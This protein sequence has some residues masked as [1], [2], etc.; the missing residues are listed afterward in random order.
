M[1]RKNGRFLRSSHTFLEC[2]NQGLLDY[3]YRAV[4]ARDLPCMA[5]VESSMLYFCSVV[6]KEHKVVLTGECADEI[7]GGYPWFRSSKAFEGQNFPWSEDMKVRQ[8]L[9]SEEWIQTLPMEEYTR[10]AYEKTIKEVP[11]LE[12]EQ[13]I[14]KRRREIAYLNLKWFMATLLDRMNRT[15]MY[16]GLEGRVPFADHRI[17]EY[18]WNVPW[19]MKCRDGVVKGLLRHAGEG[20]LPKEVLWRKRVPIPKRI[21]LHMRNCWEKSS[22]RFCG[23]PKRLW[24]SFWIK[25]RWSVFLP[26]RQIMESPGMGNSWH[27]LSDAGIYAAGELLAGEVSGENFVE[28]IL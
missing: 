11:A 2:D 5:D 28:K 12:G 27:E 16:S 10:N 19:E 4:D 9:L 6:A 26:V 22:R 13:G 20:K 1:G 14:E 15:G 25:R 8:S 23:T 7:F 17:I 18:V 21:T 24:D 3:L